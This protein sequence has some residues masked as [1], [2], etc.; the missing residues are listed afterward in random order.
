MLD[1][2]EFDAFLPGPNV[3]GPNHEQSETSDLLLGTS[4]EFKH[5]SPL[6]KEAIVSARVGHWIIRFAS[7]QFQLIVLDDETIG[8]LQFVRVVIARINIEVSALEVRGG[9]RPCI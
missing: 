6:V 7:V 3:F 9:R 5:H 2:S 1:A 4:G 8:D